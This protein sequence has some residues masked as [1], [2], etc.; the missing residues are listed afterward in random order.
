MEIDI[1]LLKQ[2]GLAVYKE[3]KPLLGTEKASEK[4]NRGAGGDITMYIDTVAENIIIDILEKENVNL[5]LISE[6]IGEKYI[7]N[8]QK[9]IENQQKII[10]DPID[11][12]NNAVRGIPFC[13]VSIAYA[14]GNSLEDIIKSVIIDLTTGDTYWAE[15]GKGA[16][17][18]DK[19]IC[20]SNRD[21]KQNCIFEVDFN[22]Y[23]LIK[24]LSDYK[25]ILQKIYK[26]RVM[27][28]TA[29]S[30]CLLAKGSIDGFLDFRRSTRLVDIAASYLIVKEAG[31]KLFSKTGEK[32]DSQLKKGAEISL[33]A[34]NAKLE[35]YL[36]EKLIKINKKMRIS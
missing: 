2:I 24:N 9:A 23:N 19:K 27:G 5:L 29:L 18:N 25:L 34:S 12:S 15:K 26:I 32:L 30:L 7:G 16:F 21:F 8:K 4:L 11:G 20:V 35:P 36:K 3:V 33:F 14:V 1:N 28:S 17:L 13:S 10:V 6:E 31:G 22:Q